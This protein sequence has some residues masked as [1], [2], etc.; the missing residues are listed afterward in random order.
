MASVNKIFADELVTEGEAESFARG[1]TDFYLE[2]AHGVQI[3]PDADI[4][5][6]GYCDH[7]VLKMH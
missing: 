5:F 7:C 3:P 6:E 1:Y 4:F 2:M